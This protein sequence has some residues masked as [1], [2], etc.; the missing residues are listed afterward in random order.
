[1]WRAALIALLA[2]PSC[3]VMTKTTGSTGVVDDTA[4]A[5]GDMGRGLEAPDR[6]ARV[7]LH[8]PISDRPAAPAMGVD[9]DA[10]ATFD[11]TRERDQ[12][13][14]VNPATDVECTAER[15]HCLPPLA[16]FWIHEGETTPTGHAHAVAFTPEGPTSPTGARAHI[17]QD[18]YTAYRTVPAT[19][20]N[21]VPG[22][23]VVV[24]PEPFPATPA[25]AFDRWT[26][27]TVERVDWE[28]G[29]VFF[30]KNR[31]PRFISSARVA[32]L[33]YRPGEKVTAVVIDGVRG[34]AE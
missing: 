3:T 12:R 20:A 19:A 21:L 28:L 9:G 18:G 32:V 16:W 15:D 1:M 29:F 31:D 11:D 30:A 5:S 27:G 2:P 23:F 24:H 25:D 10:P 8:M 6:P 26:F 14:E 22:A 4:P 13:W 7:P 33:R 17:N 34:V